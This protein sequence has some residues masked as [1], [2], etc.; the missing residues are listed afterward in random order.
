MSLNPIM[1][2][3]PDISAP[4]F[5]RD[6]LKAIGL[7]VLGYF[8]F[9]LT[10]LMAKFLQPTYGVA[11]TLFLGS[12]SGLII[13]LAW[14]LIRYGVAGFRTRHPY[15]HIT[16]GMMT[17]GTA[18]CVVQ[19][20]AVLPLAEFYGIVFIA[21]FLVLL[22][23]ALF[24]KEA[25]GWH[26][27]IAVAAGFAGILILI[28]PNLGES[29]DGLSASGIVY[30]LIAA[31]FIA[32]NVITIRKIGKGDCTPL[33]S[34]FPMICVF[35]F[36]GLFM[37]V[38]GMDWITV[39]PADMFML[40]LY[41]GGIVLGVVFVARGVGVAPLTAAVAP[42]QY[43]QILWGVIFGYVFFGDLPGV[44]TVAGLTLIVAAG[45]YAIWRE[46][47]VKAVKEET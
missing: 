13:S 29:Q 44:Y 39:R 21:P 35:I 45:L 17:C 18:F 7:V 38:K 26:R 1:S 31:F 14:L 33:F 43:S 10:D 22:F 32:G 9:N 23:S 20:V 42:F 12:I 5:R 25:I 30:T 40:L 27:G 4:D 11:Q 28:S 8:F 46:Y 3:L 6:T 16:R 24:L 47:R 19:G 2:A 41:G 34:L 37:V 15:W 36:N